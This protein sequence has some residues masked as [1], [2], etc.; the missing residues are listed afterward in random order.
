MSFFLTILPL[1]LVL[2][3]GNSFAAVLSVGPVSN[4]RCR[5]QLETGDPPP[6]EDIAEEDDDDDD[7]E[8]DKKYHG[9]FFLNKQ[10]QLKVLRAPPAL[11]AFDALAKIADSNF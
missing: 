9:I 6:P 10:G 2:L 5:L 4:T 3:A 8:E 1:S 11:G 7:W